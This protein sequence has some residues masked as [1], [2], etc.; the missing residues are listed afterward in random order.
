MI[1]HTF[2]RHVVV[3]TELDPQ[4]SVPVDYSRSGRAF[5]P[6][7]LRMEW[8]SAEGGPWGLVSATASGPVL[9][10][11]GTDSAATGKRNFQPSYRPGP[12]VDDTPAWVRELHDQHAPA[13]A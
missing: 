11:D 10:K 7:R 4:E 8:E 12:L 1:A 3:F 5:R 6:E 13:V 9:K 2:D